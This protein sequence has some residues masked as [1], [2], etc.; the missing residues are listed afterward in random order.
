M[1]GIFLNVNDINLF[2]MV[3]NL[4]C[5]RVLVQYREYE[6]I[7]YLLRFSDR[8]DRMKKLY[9]NFFI[10]S[11]WRNDFLSS[12]KS[13]S[14]NQKSGV[15]M[16]QFATSSLC[17]CILNLH[18]Q[19]FVEFPQFYSSFLESLKSWE[20]WSNPGVLREDLIYLLNQN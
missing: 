17:W 19:R 4:H 14:S 10:Q 9:G 12:G 20:I 7:S 2:L 11:Q 16:N 6:F 15:K 5:K 3:M 18:S 1:L 8:I 13:V